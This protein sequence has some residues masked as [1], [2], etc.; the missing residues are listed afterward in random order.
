[1]TFDNGQ[2]SSWNSARLTTWAITNYTQYSATV[3]GDTTIGGKSIDSWG[4]TRFGTI[5]K[6][7]RFTNKSHWEN[8]TYPSVRLSAHICSP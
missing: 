1:V 6:Q 5:L 2:T 4:Q 7:D 3:N 8:K